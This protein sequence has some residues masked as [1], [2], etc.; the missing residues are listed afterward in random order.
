MIANLKFY[1]YVGGRWVE[2]LPSAIKTSDSGANI[3]A[4]MMRCPCRLTL[5]ED[6]RDKSAR[7]ALS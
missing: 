5:H 2:Q 1:S 7:L 4:S 3:M 6:T